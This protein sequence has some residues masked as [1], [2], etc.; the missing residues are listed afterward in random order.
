MAF[1]NSSENVFMAAA[2]PLACKNCSSKFE[3]LQIFILSACLEAAKEISNT[4]LNCF[5]T[6]IWIFYRR[7]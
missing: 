4:H 2:V 1:Q 3:W 6:L 7:R 5:Q